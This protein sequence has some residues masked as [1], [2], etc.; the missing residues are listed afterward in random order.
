VHPFSN[1]LHN[2]TL[3][4][5]YRLAAKECMA[6]SEKKA[7]LRLQQQRLRLQQ[8]RAKAERKGHLSKLV[9][10]TVDVL[11]SDKQVYFLKNYFPVFLYNVAVLNILIEGLT[12]KGQ[13]I[14]GS[15]KNFVVLGLSSTLLIWFFSIARVQFRNA[16]GRTGLLSFWIY[17]IVH[18]FIPFWIFTVWC[19][20]SYSGRSRVELILILNTA[21]LAV[22]TLRVRRLYNAVTG[23]KSF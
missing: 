10:N 2:D 1:Y 18:P 16:S 5:K 8:Q 14:S 9:K 13:Y 22:L 6:E 21:L 19:E 17:M 15:E 3:K 12:V 20:I 23:K 4:Q 11:V 7:E